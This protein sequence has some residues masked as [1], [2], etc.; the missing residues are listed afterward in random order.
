MLLGLLALY[1]E[2]QVTLVNQIQSLQGTQVELV[3]A[4]ISKIWS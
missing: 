4:Y 1:P 3:S 2:E